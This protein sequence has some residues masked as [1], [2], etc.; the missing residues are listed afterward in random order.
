MVPL[1]TYQVLA[2]PDFNNYVD[3]AQATNEPEIVFDADVAASQAVLEH[4]ADAIDMPLVLVSRR[5][6]SPIQESV[7]LIELTL[8]APITL[9]SCPFSPPHNMMNDTS[10]NPSWSPLSCPAS[11]SQSFITVPLDICSTLESPQES[12]ILRFHRHKPRLP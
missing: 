7:N 9:I 8:K 10:E 4:E 3:L 12:V 2:T 11:I 5:A 6:P 1:P